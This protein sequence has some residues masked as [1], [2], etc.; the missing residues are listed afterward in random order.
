MLTGEEFRNLK[1]LFSN[2]KGQIRVTNKNAYLLWIL[3]AP[4]DVA[5]LRQHRD[6][7]MHVLKEFFEAVQHLS[8]DTD[9]KTLLD[10]WEN[11]LLCVPYGG[12]E[13]VSAN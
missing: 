9:V 13:I 10:E 1:P 3:L 6:I 2:S 8:Q 12:E 7:Y 5:L 4:L 11:R